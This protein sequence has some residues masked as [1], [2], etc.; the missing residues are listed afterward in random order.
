VVAVFDV[1]DPGKALSAGTLDQL[2]D[3]LANKVAET[4]AWRVIPRDQ[5]RQRLMTEKTSS[6]KECFDQSCQI[7][8]GKAVAAQKS[9]ATKVLRVEAT[10]AVT[11][12][13]FDL[14]TET[15]ER[16]ATVRAGCSAA[17]LM[18]A[19]DKIAAQLLADAK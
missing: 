12:T 3:Y 17:T 1:Q 4:G 9:L 7:D 13:L 19:L 5:L 18:D 10:C 6:F 11:T 8:L 2:T 14:K 16:A 15:T